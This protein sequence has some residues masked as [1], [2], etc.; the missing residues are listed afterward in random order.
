MDPGLRAVYYCTEKYTDRNKLGVIYDHEISAMKL[1]RPKRLSTDPESRIRDCEP[2]IIALKLYTD[3][4]KLG[5][6]HT[7]MKHFFI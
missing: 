1:N 4:N 2:Y 5:N 7:I 3:R 6:I